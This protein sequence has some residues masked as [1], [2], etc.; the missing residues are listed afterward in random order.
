[1]LIVTV[2]AILV[3]PDLASATV[4]AVILILLKV[5]ADCRF[6]VCLP[7]P[8]APTHL[9][10]EPSLQAAF[11]AQ[12][13][14]RMLEE[15]AQILETVP[16]TQLSLQWD[17]AVEFAL[18]EGVMPTYMPEPEPEIIR[19]LI[20]LG[21]RVPEPVELGFHLCYGD[22]GHKHFCEPQDASILVRI[23]SSVLSAGMPYPS[24]T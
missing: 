4:F 8:L 17:T 6:Q 7:T 11:D 16:H 20:D 21:E 14:A 9:F 24:P 12:Y 15:L 3:F 2:G 23:A 19:R 5:A 22:S 10:V 1:M 13:E 18:L